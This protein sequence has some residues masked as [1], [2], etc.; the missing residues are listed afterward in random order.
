MRVNVSQLLLEEIGTRRALDFDGDA[1]D[2]QVSGTGQLLRTDVGILVHVECEVPVSAVCGRCLQ[3]FTREMCVEFDEEYFPSID[4]ATGAEL[5]APDEE[6]YMIDEHHE[7]DLWPAVREYSILTEPMSAICR[8]GDCRG[9]C[10]QC[11]ADQNKGPCS[12][13]APAAH[14]AFEALRQDWESAADSVETKT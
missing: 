13:R 10:N 6:T 14:A 11:G 7:L 2:S 8:D 12:C 1:Q 5:A 4:M 9:L 3:P